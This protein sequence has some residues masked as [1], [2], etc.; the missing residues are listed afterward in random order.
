VS[1]HLAAHRDHV[2]QRNADYRAIC[3]RTEFKQL[4]VV[5]GP[6]DD[7]QSAPAARILDHPS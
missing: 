6:L 3:D 5:T 4:S 7:V 2:A 1:S